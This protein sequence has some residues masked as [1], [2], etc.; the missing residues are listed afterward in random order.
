M[1]RAVATLGKKTAVATARE[2]LTHLLAMLASGA[3]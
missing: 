2:A 3:T 1:K